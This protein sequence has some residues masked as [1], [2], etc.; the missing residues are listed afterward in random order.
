MR[1]AG[2]VSKCRRSRRIVREVHALTDALDAELWGSALLG[3]LWSRRDMLSFDERV[4]EDYCFDSG[5]PLIEAVAQVGDPDARGAL[6][7]IAEVDDG[8]LGV[9]AR[10]L[11]G[12]MPEDADGGA[13]RLV[14]RRSAKPRR[15]ISPEG[16]DVA[17]DSGA[18]VRFAGRKSKLPDWAT[19]ATRKSI[20]VWHETMGDR[21]QD[22]EAGGQFCRRLE[23]PQPGQLTLQPLGIFRPMPLP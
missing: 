22:P 16:A 1:V 2:A 7:V 5:A 6:A 23:P 8:E 15:D 11:L 17:S 20:P 4:S 18:W 21:S 3:L 19:A 12:K 13:A 10:E 9:L 14:R